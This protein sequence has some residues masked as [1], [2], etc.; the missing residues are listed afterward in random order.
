M[1][2]KQDLVVTQKRYMAKVQFN[3]E[4]TGLT[5]GITGSAFDGIGGLTGERFILGITNNTAALSRISWTSNSSTGGYSLQWNTTNGAA[6]ITAISVYGTD[7]ERDFERVTIKN[8]DPSPFGTFRIT[9]IAPT[10]SG[11]VI[12]EFVHASG[13]VT[14]PGYLGL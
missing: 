2:T 4:S 11:T 13:S 7:G 1:A 3:N 8:N 12:V 14:P 9:P 6:G 10:S 5:F